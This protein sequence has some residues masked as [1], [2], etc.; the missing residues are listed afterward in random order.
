[1]A[2]NEFPNLGTNEEIIKEDSAKHVLHGGNVKQ[3]GRLILTNQRFLFGRET[4]ILFFFAKKTIPAVDIH[5]DQIRKVST[6]GMVRKQ[7]Q[8]SFEENG[9]YEDA[10][11][12]VGDVDEWVAKLEELINAE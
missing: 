12:Q 9:S 6:K 5:L 8:V 10:I 3:G 4:S 2:K 7:L 11:F 1:M